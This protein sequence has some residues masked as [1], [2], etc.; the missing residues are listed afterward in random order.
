MVSLGANP[1]RIIPA[2]N[3]VVDTF[4]RA[5]RPFRG[6]GE[7][8]WV[9]RPEDEL[10]ECLLHEHLLNVAFE[11]GPA[12]QLFCPYDASR[13]P[14]SAVAAAKATHPVWSSHEAVPTASGYDC[15]SAAEAFAQPLP[16]APA[17]A[18]SF[19][20]GPSDLV[21]IRALVSERAAG[22]G[23]TG[24]RCRDLVLA[25]SELATNS[26]RYGGGGG[27]LRHWHTDRALIVDFVDDGLIND[28]L[29]GRRLPALARE[30]GRGLFLV[31]QICDFVQVRS[32]ARGTHVRVSTR[33]PTE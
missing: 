2:W 20:F 22:C 29:A 1:A 11:A 21:R 16:A 5:G 27:L 25:A 7:P 8:V 17:D 24:D 19:A 23:I 26:L 28:L 33:R 30:G 10:D 3:N 18:A 9:G 13:L 4:T 31:N 6:I 32:S 15:G 12:W 14:A